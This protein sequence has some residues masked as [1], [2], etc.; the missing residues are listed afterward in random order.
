MSIILAV[1]VGIVAG[2]A[3]GYFAF[4]SVAKVV[5]HSIVGMFRDQLYKSLIIRYI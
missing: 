3:F 1:I 4:R 5:I 2:L